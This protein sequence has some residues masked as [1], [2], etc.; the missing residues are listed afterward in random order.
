MSGPQSVA[1]APPLGRA[2]LVLA[3]ATTVIVATEFI[4][5]GLLPVLATDL[6]VP[7]SQAGHLVG[8][9]A[10]SAALLGPPLTLAAARLSPSHVMA[11]TLLIFGAGNLVAV[12][13]P[14]YP[15]LLAVR[16]VQGAGLPLFVSVGT[17]AVTLLAPAARRGR[18]L[19]LANIGFTLGLVLALPA[20][21]ALAERG[22]WSI[23]FIALGLLSVGAALLTMLAFPPLPARYAPA[24]AGQARLLL[25]A[26]FVTHLLLSVVSFAAMF[27]SYT[28]LAA[29]LEDHAGLSRPAIAPAL[30]FFGAAGLVGNAAVAAFADREPIASTLLSLCAGAAGAIGASLLPGQSFLFY[31][32]LGLWGVAHTAAVTACQV[33]VTLAGMEAPAFAMAMNISSANLGIAL[34][35]LAGGLVVDRWGLAAIGW[36]AASLVLV[37]A[38]VAAAARYVAP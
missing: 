19:A 3:L 8:A 33:R 28:Y 25:R 29:W 36:G 23:S 9:F 38:G 35:A 11:A 10:L 32:L 2:L 14:T 12:L 17:A 26:R 27:A 22:T 7:L 31:L 20:G 18:I 4:V 24:P 16:V 5:V 30:I 1:A 13:S 15:T 6:G 34:G 37:A 21:V